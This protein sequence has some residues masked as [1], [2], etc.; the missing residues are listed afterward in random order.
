MTWPVIA[1]SVRS[2]V[3]FIL[4]LCTHWRGGG[5]RGDARRVRTV[6][7]NGKAEQR[8]NRCS[9]Q[10]TIPNGDF[11]FGLLVKNFSSSCVMAYL[12]MRRTDLTM[13]IVAIVLVGLFWLH[14][15]LN[16]RIIQQ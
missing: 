4:P 2:G 3:F 16:R 10:H 15:W 11:I 1:G 7:E 5:E 12:E 8:P 13:L 9:Y 6:G 14:V